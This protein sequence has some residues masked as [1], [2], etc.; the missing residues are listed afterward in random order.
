MAIPFWPRLVLRA[1][2]LHFGIVTRVLAV[3]VWNVT[4]DLPLLTRILLFLFCV[5]SYC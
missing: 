5:C 3:I 2:T 1:A 4:D